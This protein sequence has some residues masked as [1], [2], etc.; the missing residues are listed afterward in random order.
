MIKYII[1]TYNITLVQ[2][3]PI[4]E[5]RLGTVGNVSDHSLTIEK[6]RSLNFRRILFPFV[7]QRNK[8]LI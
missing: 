5:D 2:T 7:T 1:Y 4:S 8:S 6:G 3:L